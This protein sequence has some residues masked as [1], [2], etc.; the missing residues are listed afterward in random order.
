MVFARGRDGERRG[1]GVPT[2]ESKREGLGGSILIVVAATGNYTCVKIHRI[3][4]T[5]G[6]P[7]S[8]LIFKIK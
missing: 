5:S 7:Y 6:Q 2:R 3:A 1:S 4:H 8:T